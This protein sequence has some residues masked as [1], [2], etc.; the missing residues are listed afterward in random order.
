MVKDQ[1]YRAALL[2]KPTDE[3]HEASQATAS[4]LATELAGILEV[5][6]ALVATLD[7]TWAELLALAAGKRAQRGGFQRRLPLEYTE[8]GK[9]ANTP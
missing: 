6:T 2:A 4:D 8:H 3:A 7:M 9:P 5:L 1:G